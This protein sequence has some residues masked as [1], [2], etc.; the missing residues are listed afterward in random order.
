M[1]L[2]SWLSLADEEGNRGAEKK[3]AGPMNP[4]GEGESVAE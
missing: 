4:M 2:R 1:R 3:L